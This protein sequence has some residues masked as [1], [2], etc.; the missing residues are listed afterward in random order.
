MRAYAVQ[1]EQLDFIIG[2]L[3]SIRPSLPR[4]VPLRACYTNELMLD[5]LDLVEL[6]ARIEQRFGLRVPDV[7]LD[8]FMSVEATA[9]YLAAR[10]TPKR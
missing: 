7:D 5:S 1:Q 9:Q 4:D 10:L 8:H 3:R 6:A 2:E